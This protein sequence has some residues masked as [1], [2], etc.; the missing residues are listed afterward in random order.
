MEVP[1][2]IPGFGTFYLRTQSLG[3]RIAFFGK[4]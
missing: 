2:S 1:A 4:G 3:I